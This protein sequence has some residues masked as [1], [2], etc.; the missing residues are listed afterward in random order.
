MDMNR[1]ADK[2]Q[3]VSRYASRILQLGSIKKLQTE[4]YCMVFVAI[5]YTVLTVELNNIG[6]YTNLI[7]P[8]EVAELEH[9]HVAQRIQ[10]SKVVLIVEQ[11][12]C[13][14]IWGCKACLLM[15]YSTLTTASRQRI[16]VYIVGAY[17]AVNYVVMLILFFG[18]WCRPFS[19]YWAFPVQ[20]SQ[21]ATYHNH[22]IV[23]SVFNISSDIMM[24]CIPLPIL[25]RLKLPLKKKIILCVVFSL[26]IFVILSAI[27]SKYYS[28]SL[29]YGTEWTS[30]YV[31][32]IGTAVI[33]ANIPHCWVLVRKAFHVRSFLSNGNS[34]A[35]SRG[36][37]GTF[38]RD[39]LKLSSHAAGMSRAGNNEPQSRWYKMKMVDNSS[40]PSASGIGFSRSES[41]ERI[42]QKPL[43]IYQDVRYHVDREHARGGDKS[44]ADSL[45]KGLQGIHNGNS[46]PE[47]AG[48]LQQEEWKTKT[49][50]TALPAP[51]LT[52]K[53]SN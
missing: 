35:R 48:P 31:R 11:F 36:G 41:E 39:G 26:G 30:W 28:F 13:A 42:N 24:L 15:L 33:V 12:W 37:T 49:V 8:T 47:F 50:V 3:V 51:E 27:L 5:C 25:V 23:N 53:N 52:R 38:N 4:D 43:E 45:E 9:D 7:H 44:D 18:V 32:E 2:R 21:C 1:E 40:T 16:L 22:L 19:Q 34:T 10:G 46:S 14:T 20:N 29:P 6:I 17:V